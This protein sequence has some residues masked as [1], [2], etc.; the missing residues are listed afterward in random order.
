V[1]TNH[2]FQVSR[3]IGSLLAG[4]LTLSMADVQLVDIDVENW[5]AVAG[6][7]THPSQER[8][9]R[10]SLFS[11]A[12][13]QFY[14][15]VQLKAA[16]DELGQPVGL[17]MYGLDEED[18]HYWIFRLVIDRAHQRR[19]YGRSVTQEVIRELA[20]LPDCREIR[21]RYHPDNKAAAELY[22]R[23]GFTDE[24]RYG[25]QVLTRL[26]FVSS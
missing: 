9:V 8:F 7:C 11:I 12:E 6:L 23:A 26:R 1:C 4:S 2:A 18:G 21:V 17:V 22:R 3:R 16:I 20:G 10:S 25:D 19:G 15:D 5:R 14:P 24:G 13:A